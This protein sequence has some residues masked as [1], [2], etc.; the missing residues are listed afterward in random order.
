MTVLSVFFDPANHISEKLNPDL[1]AIW[2]SRFGIRIGEQ[3]TKNPFIVAKSLNL[4]P[5]TSLAAQLAYR[6]KFDILFSW[7]RHLMRQYL[8]LKRT[9]H[10]IHR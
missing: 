1:P 6:S 2:F 3:A 8:G 10:L 4:D 9:S 7:Q 5:I